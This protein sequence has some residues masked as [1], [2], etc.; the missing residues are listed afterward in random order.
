M[1]ILI[2]GICGFVGST[3][4]RTLAE[5]GYA[6]S[7]CGL[8]NFIRPGSETNRLPLI[9]CGISVRHADIR[10]AS[11]FE[12]LPDADWV[13]DAA[14]N[15]SI[16]AGI[17]GRT[18]PR[19]LIEHNLQGTV[20]MLEFCRARNAGFILLSTSRVYSIAKLSALQVEVADDAY[21]PVLTS[22]VPGLSARGVSEE[23]STAAPVSLYGATKLASEQLALEYGD[24][25]GLPVW[26]D[27]CGVLA[28]AG[29][30]GRPDQGIFAYWIHSWARHAPLT[31]LGFDGLGHQVRDCLH[32]RDIVPL[33][34]RQMRESAT[35]TQRIVHVS[36]GPESAC[37]LKQ[38]SRWCAERFGPHTVTGEPRTR[39]YDIPWLVLDN[40]RAK[41]DWAWEPRTRRED[42]FEEIARHAESE[43]D[44]L[45]RSRLG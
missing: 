38:C 7:I 31:Y 22:A 13:I 11:D 26:I 35:G 34:E 8:D 27:R 19:Q 16:L 6:G 18:G 29:Q 43:P 5:S 20:N 14:A 2:T 41:A 10:C 30:F 32:P 24:A 9:E 45:E 37:S 39:A 4:A 1:R 17:D 44:W 21:R 3:I 25:F 33:L 12:A 15:P 23:F 42:I 40:R 36:G 28:G